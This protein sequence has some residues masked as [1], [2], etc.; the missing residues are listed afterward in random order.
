MLK[1]FSGNIKKY[2]KFYSFIFQPQTILILHL[3]IYSSLNIFQI[4]YKDFTSLLSTN[5]LDI[6]SDEKLFSPFQEL[7]CV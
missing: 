7:T 2:S 6:I 4:N 5:D 1:Y 3:W